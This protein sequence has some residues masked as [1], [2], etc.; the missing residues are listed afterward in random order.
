M[1]RVKAVIERSSEGRYSI[2]MDAPTMSYL[3]TAE[4]ATLEEA[5]SD[6]MTYYNETKEY[7]QSHNEA[8]EEVEFDFYDETK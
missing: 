4:G 2:Y 3:I 5:K 1:K 7:F 6:F 8:F